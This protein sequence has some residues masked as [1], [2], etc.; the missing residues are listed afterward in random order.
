MFI[1]QACRDFIISFIE[2]N[3]NDTLQTLYYSINMELCIL[4]CECFLHI[5]NNLMAKDVV[6]MSRTCKYAYNIC[7]DEH[8]WRKLI[9]DTYS[10]CDKIMDTST[11]YRHFISM[12]KVFTPLHSVIINKVKKFP[13]Q[14]NVLIS[15]CNYE[16][17]KGLSDINTQMGIHATTDNF[18][19][20]THIVIYCKDDTVQICVPIQSK[21]RYI[22]MNLDITTAHNAESFNYIHVSNE[23]LESLKDKQYYINEDAHIFATTFSKQ[24]LQIIGRFMN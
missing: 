6:N 2:E 3:K 7:R 24:H 14:W 23:I 18:L 16:T 19:S 22:L 4:P 17:Y 11:W 15:L 8:L 9:Y 20:L 12:S 1:H 5:L 10:M 21:Y 13:H